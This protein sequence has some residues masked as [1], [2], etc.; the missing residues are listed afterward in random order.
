[1]CPDFRANSLFYVQA[2]NG[3]RAFTLMAIMP[4]QLEANLSKQ[5]EVQTKT[6]ERIDCLS[7]YS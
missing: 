4:G 7:I 1:M 2:H 6:S 3:F 5:I